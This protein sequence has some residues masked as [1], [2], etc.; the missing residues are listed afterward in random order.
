VIGAGYA[1]GLTAA[2]LEQF[3]AAVDWEAVVGGTGADCCSRSSQKRL[4]TAASS[5]LEL[6]VNNHNIVT[7]AGLANTSGIDDLLRTYVAQA[8]MVPDFDQLPIPYRAVATDMVTGKMVVLSRGDLARAMR[9]SMA[10]PGAFSP[11]V[12]KGT[13]SPTA[14]RCATS[15]WTW[16]ARPAP[17]SSSS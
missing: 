4:K 10:I 13:C 1:A 16:R 11:V 6:G 12:W 7:R 8:R 2:Q 5:D 9:A 3:V 15:R 14:A 17:T